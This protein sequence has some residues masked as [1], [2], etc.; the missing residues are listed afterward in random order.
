[1]TNRPRFLDDVASKL[2]E[3][4][5]SSPA[6]DLERNAK[7]LLGGAFSKL[8]LVS[9]EEFDI[10]KALLERAVLRLQALEARLAQLESPTPEP[11]TDTSAPV[12]A[13]AALPPS[14]T[15]HPPAA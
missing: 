2:A 14:G 9:R 13:P 15:P 12:D 10:Q 3:L 5:A 11:A 4:A 7:A 6:R 8:D 1:M